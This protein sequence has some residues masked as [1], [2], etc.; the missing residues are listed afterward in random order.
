MTTCCGQEN[1]LEIYLETS[2][3]RMDNKLNVL[4]WWNKESVTFKVLSRMTK[5]FLSVQV[6]T[7]ISERAFSTSGRL[8]SNF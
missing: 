3:E 1:E 4:E 2:S 7:T 5:D 8:I 6:S